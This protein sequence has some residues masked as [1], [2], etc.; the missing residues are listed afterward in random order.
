MPALFALN[1]ARESR[2]LIDTTKNTVYMAGYGDYDLMQA[3]PPGTQQFNCVLPHSGHMMIPCVELQVASEVGSRG[4]LRLTHELMLPVEG[5][6]EEEPQV[7]G[8]PQSDITRVV[9][10]AAPR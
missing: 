2:L 5:V 7:A 4:R 8:Q 6:P 9:A 10:F 3:L 1:A